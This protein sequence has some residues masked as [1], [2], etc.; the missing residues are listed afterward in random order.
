MSSVR[1]AGAL[2]AARTPLALWA[3]CFP[4]SA[5][6]CSG[7]SVRPPLMG[8]LRTLTDT[9]EA[10]SSRTAQGRKRSSCRIGAKHAYMLTKLLQPRQGFSNLRL[11]QRSFEIDKE[12]VLAQAL[13]HRS[14]LDLRQIDLPT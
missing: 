7:L 8:D 13:T 10:R 6:E 2:R 9:V 5:P 4:S 11:R 1:A 3:P 14:R 12:H